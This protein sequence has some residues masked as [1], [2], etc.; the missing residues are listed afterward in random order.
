M[1]LKHLRNF[2]LAW[3]WS[4]LLGQTIAATPR[5][6]S[7]GL[8]P[9]AVVYLDTASAVQRDG[10]NRKFWTVTDYKR[11]QT[12]SSGQ[13]YRSTRSWMEIDCNAK[14]ARV[15]HLTFFEGPLQSGKPI[16]REGILHDWIAITPDSPISRLAYKVC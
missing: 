5:L 14:Q 16:E 11:M 9:H 4:A 8:Y 13:F 12:H 10:G 6:Q 15:L 7:L 3:V 1:K 2:C